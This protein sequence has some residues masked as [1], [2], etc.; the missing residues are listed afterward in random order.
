M[1][2][3]PSSSDLNKSRKLAPF[4]VALTATLLFSACEDKHIGRPCDLGVP[5]PSDPNL[6]TVNAQALECP[7]RICVLPARLRSMQ[8]DTTPTGPLC[9]DQCGSD[10]DCAG[11]ET[12]GKT[13]P[14]CD[15]G[16]VCRTVLP[17]LDNNPASCKPICVCKDFLPS[18][19]TPTVPDS[20]K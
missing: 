14:K 18:M 15:T 10:D 1:T 17:K 20:C 8:A 19:D 2:S 9:T 6:I 5:I 13:D 3:L 16:F 7:S 12:G 11:G 4:L